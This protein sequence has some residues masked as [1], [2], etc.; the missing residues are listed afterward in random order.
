M[1]R[2]R[3]AKFDQT[4]KRRFGLE[5][6]FEERH[7]SNGYKCRM[8]LG[9]RAPCPI[10]QKLHVLV[11]DFVGEDHRAAPRL[12]DTSLTHE[13]CIQIHR[14]LCLLLWKLY[15]QCKLVHADFS[16]YNILVVSVKS[17]NAFLKTEMF[18]G[19]LCGD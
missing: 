17:S 8:C 2:K 4:Q 19:E 1:G 6:L 5:V 15:S 7:E 13:A 18:E 12:K 11:M 10:E 9:I 14:E 16:E 3:D